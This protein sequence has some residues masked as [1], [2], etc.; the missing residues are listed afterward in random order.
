MPPS[1]PTTVFLDIDIGDPTTHASESEAYARACTFLRE[2]GAMY[3][4][5][6]GT[7]KPE[8]LDEGQR[9]VLEEV[10]EADPASKGGPFRLTPPTPLH[11]GRL[12]I[13]L[14]TTTTPKTCANF[15][16]LCTHSHGTSKLDKKTP[17]HYKSAAFHRIIRSFIAQGG[18]ITRHDGSGG[19]SI[20][21][22]K[23]NDEKEG[24]KAKFERGSV[25]MA[26]SGKNSNTSQFFV[27]VT[28]EEGKLAKLNGKHVVFGKVREECFGVLDKIDAVGSEHGVPRA[29]VVIADCGVVS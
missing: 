3:G 5:G 26:N 13:D 4:L 24:L 6:D 28:G 21:G 20:Y 19:D 29:K 25:G 23:F 7:T 1:K 14:H 15:L 22:G 27:V 11:A 8:E 10:Y 9:E 16:A 18:D 12:L 17:L 2:K